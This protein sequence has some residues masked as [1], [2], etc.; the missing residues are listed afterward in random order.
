M[1]SGCCTVPC[2]IRAAISCITYRVVSEGRLKVLVGI[3]VIWLWDR[4]LLGDDHSAIHIQG[5]KRGQICE[6]AEWD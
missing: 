6:G 4:Y 3:D 1:I 2:R 5:Q